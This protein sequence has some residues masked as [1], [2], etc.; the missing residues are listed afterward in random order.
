MKLS[1]IT[2]DMLA[3]LAAPYT[4]NTAAELEERIRKFCKAD[5]YLIDQ[6]RITTVSPLSKH[7]IIMHDPVALAGDWTYWKN[8]SEALLLRCSALLV[9]CMDG[10][11]TSTGVRGE[12]DFAVRHNIP[13]IF[14]NE[15]GTEDE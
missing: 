10:Y 4:A 1:D 11:D 14:L 2:P 9:L 3:Y 6:H 5:A 15:D 7:M 13:I 8:Y 12:I